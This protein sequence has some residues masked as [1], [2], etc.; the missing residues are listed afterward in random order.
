MFANVE[1][2]KKS[3]EEAEKASR[4]A[5]MEK[6]RIAENRALAKAKEPSAK[7]TALSTSRTLQKAQMESC[8][9]PWELLIIN[10]FTLSGSAKVA[11]S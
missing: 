4:E 8:M 10:F 2:I 1:S 9:F 7:A 3:L 6:T 11:G 5:E